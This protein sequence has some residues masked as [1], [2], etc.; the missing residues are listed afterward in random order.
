MQ[1]LRKL[2]HVH[3]LFVCHP[4][5]S[6]AKLIP[7][8]KGRVNMPEEFSEGV[9]MHLFALIL[10]CLFAQASLVEGPVQGQVVRVLDGDTLEVRVTVWLDLVVTT[11]V[12]L[13]AV[14]A[15]EIWRPACNAERQQGMRAKALIEKAVDKNAVTLIG[16]KRGKY[17]G[18]V[19]AYVKT[20]DG[21]DLSSLLIEEKL[22]DLSLCSGKHIAAASVHSK[23]QKD[24]SAK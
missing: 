3:L 1:Q 23:S 5:D 9:H 14:N 2:R 18:R 16:V 22:T 6:V 19:I 17:A 24:Q 4:K 7:A 8:W 15:P 12:R 20:G 10:F 11:K 21:V 13:A